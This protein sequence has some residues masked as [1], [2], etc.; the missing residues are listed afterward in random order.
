MRAPLFSACFFRSKITPSSLRRRCFS[1]NPDVKC[2]R[3]RTVFWISTV[4]RMSL[5]FS[6]PISEFPY[7]NQEKPTY[8]NPVNCSKK[9][10]CIRVLYG[11]FQSGTS[12]FVLQTLPLSSYSFSS[13]LDSNVLSHMFEKLLTLGPG[14]SGRTFTS[15]PASSV[16]YTTLIFDPLSLQ[17]SKGPVPS[18]PDLELSA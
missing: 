3:A 12:D 16:S 17:D 9:V 5:F 8:F 1:K 6:P 10:D 18:T 7:I 15:R 13:L 11:V 14:P 4:E 2:C